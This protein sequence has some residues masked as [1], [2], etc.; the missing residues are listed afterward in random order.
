LVGRSEPRRGD[1][2]SCA[3]KRGG[4]KIPAQSS[5]LVRVLIA[6]PDA[7]FLKLADFLLPR[8]GLLVKLTQRIGVAERLVE[9]DS[10]DVVVL[11][12]SELDPHAIAERLRARRPHVGVVLVS[13]NEQG[14]RFGASKALTKWSMS[15]LG[16]AILAAHLRSCA[17]CTGQA[18]S[19]H[20]A[21]VHS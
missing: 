18:E 6:S 3:S 13:E 20:E 11:D 4:T 14:E 16:D 21:G 19:R 1:S 15:D 9:R 8:A 2:L 17:A 5:A 10:A 7:R 12:E